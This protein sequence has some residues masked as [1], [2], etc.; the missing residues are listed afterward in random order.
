MSKT[1][2][3]GVSASNL[4]IRE[5]SIF[6]VPSR[7]VSVSFL[8]LVHLGDLTMRVRA[9]NLQDAEP[10]VATPGLFFVSFQSG[11]DLLRQSA[12]MYIASRGVFL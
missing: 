6:G 5:H 1:A 9:L 8:C 3:L 4:R 7:L 11:S 10:V 12:I 2:V